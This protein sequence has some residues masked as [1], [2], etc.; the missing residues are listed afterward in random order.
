M[1]GRFWVF[2][3]RGDFVPGRFCP[4][5]IKGVSHSHKNSSAH[6]ARVVGLQTDAVVVTETRFKG[7]ARLQD[8]HNWLHLEEK[9]F[10]MTNGEKI[11]L[12]SALCVAKTWW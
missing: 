7:L 1:P 12:A 4:G 3:I 10:S 11:Y 6:M 2:L 5:K 8:F 9:A